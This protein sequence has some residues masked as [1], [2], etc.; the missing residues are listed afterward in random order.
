[1]RVF[2]I[3]AA[4][5]VLFLIFDENQANISDAKRLED[6]TTPSAQVSNSTV[7]DTASGYGFYEV[8]RKRA[9][10]ASECRQYG[11]FAEPSLGNWTMKKQLSQ[12]LLV[13][14]HKKY[15]REYLAIGFGERNLFG[16][17]DLKNCL[18]SY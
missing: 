10:T 12:G 14:Y 11:G 16:S 17:Y 9:S 6:P 4:V 5:V 1:V 15:K 7:A 13:I 3:I 2:I 18:F 8:A